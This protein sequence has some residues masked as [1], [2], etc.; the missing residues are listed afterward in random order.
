MTAIPAVPS[1]PPLTGEAALTDAE[2]AE[3]EARAAAATEGPWQTRWAGQQFYVF[4]LH[5]DETEY[6]AEWTYAVRT[7]EPEAT[8]DRAECMTS[9]AEFIA[10]ARTDVP[11]LVASLRSAREEL[12]S[13]RAERVEL[14]A[15]RDQARPDR[16][17]AKARLH[18]VLHELDVRITDLPGDCHCN[19]V[20]EVILDA[21]YGRE[22]QTEEGASRGE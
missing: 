2:L 20:A 10:A 21:L 1:E 6:V 9:D 8:A 15:E 22:G 5:D 4:G 19:L 16:E 12:M 13:A 14:I 3:I 11:R 17:A 7:W 18:P